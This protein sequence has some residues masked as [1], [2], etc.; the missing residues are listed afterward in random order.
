MAPGKVGLQQEVEGPVQWLQFF[1]K[2]VG[3]RSYAEVCGRNRKG[4]SRVERV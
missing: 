1:F 3:C 2:K 4:K